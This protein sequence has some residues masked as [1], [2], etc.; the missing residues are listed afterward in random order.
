MQSRAR[1]SQE[2]EA[3]DTQDIAGSERKLVRRVIEAEWPDC[4]LPEGIRV[5]AR[6]RWLLSWEINRGLSAMRAE[7]WEPSKARRA[8]GFR[9][10]PDLPRNSH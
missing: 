3:R 8:K 9:P 6:S 5:C 7:P 1:C 10:G 2:S 4:T